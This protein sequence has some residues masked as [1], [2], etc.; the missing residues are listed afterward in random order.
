MCGPAKIGHLE[1][2]L[3]VQVCLRDGL[4]RMV[5]VLA[6]LAILHWY[7]WRFHHQVYNL[8][9]RLNLGSFLKGFS[10]LLAKGPEEQKKKEKKRIKEEERRML[11]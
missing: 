7:K 8:W 9:P 1:D 6:I 11:G 2:I 3:L 5:Q 4:I 10:A